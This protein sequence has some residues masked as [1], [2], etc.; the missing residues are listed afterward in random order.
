M[1][2]ASAFGLSVEGT[3]GG[4]E[5][6]LC[7]FHDDRKASAWFHPK[8]E[9]FYCAVCNM[10]LNGRQLAAR[11]GLEYEGIKAYGDEEPPDF[12]LYDSS[13]PL[14]LG[15]EFYAMYMSQRGVKH[16]TCIEYG[17]RWKGG[18]S[19]AAV[20]PITT[21]GRVIVGAQ[22]RY[23]KPELEG[24][25]YR[26]IGDVTPVWPMHNL[27]A[28]APGSL[29]VV[30]EGVF[31]ALR[32]HSF[33]EKNGVTGIYPFALMGAKANTRILQLLSHL[34]PFFLYDK[35]D[36]GYKACTKMRSLGSDVRA[37]VTK[38]PDDMSEGEMSILL[39]NLFNVHFKDNVTHVSET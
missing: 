21:L 22:Y 28:L 24:T 8:K 14:E 11:M 7:P 2:S 10:G 31:S 15:E 32:L 34:K 13:P 33:M 30:T 39:N 23:E 19:P 29:L 9:L 35:D 5:L 18:P 26:I 25:R 20:F 6:V 17:V 12:D 16:S 4:E 37:F 3:S 1:T 38:S 27:Y 36:A